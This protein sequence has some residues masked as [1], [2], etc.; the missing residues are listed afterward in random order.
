MNAAEL[1]PSK[2]MVAAEFGLKNI[3]REPLVTIASVQIEEADGSEQWPI[4]RW[5]EPWAKPYKVNA[6]A[7]KALVAMFGTETDHW[8]GKR[9]VLFGLPGVYFGEHGVAV[10]IKGS[11]DLREEKTITV[12]K[13]GGKKKDTY[14]LVPIALKGQAQEARPAAQPRAEPAAA[15]APAASSKP[16]PE[17]APPKH[18]ANPEHDAQPPVSAVTAPVAADAPQAPPPPKT[19]PQPAFDPKTAGPLFPFGK[20]KGSP[21]ERATNPQILETINL[22][23][24]KKLEDKTLN[25]GQVASIDKGINE[26][27]LE[28]ERRFKLGMSTPAPAAN[29]PAREPGSDG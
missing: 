27:R 14:K 20:W 8:V 1:I 12:K 11:P 24:T 21:L 23:E 28:L 19:P 10:R 29:E 3:P 13:F 25:A 6:T 15:P 17:P 9:L 22:G 18:D 7:R 26:M 16:P 2:W 5:R 4:I